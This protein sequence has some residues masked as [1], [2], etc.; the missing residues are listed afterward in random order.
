MKATRLI[1]VARLCRV[2]IAALCLSVTGVQAGIL[3]SL[4]DKVTATMSSLPRYEKLPLFDPHR[5][6]FACVY[7]DQH[8]PANDPQAEVWF[9]QALALNSPDIYYQDRD[10]PK[11]YQLYLQAAE[12]NHWKAMLNLA[13]LIVG[14][15][16]GVPEQNREIAIR[17]VEKA[18]Q[19]GVPDAYDVMGTYHQNGMIRG[20]DATSAYAFFQRAADMGSPSAMTYLGYKMAGTYDD[21]GEG[22]W[23]NLAVAVPMLECAFA[24]GYGDAGE[25]LSL[26]YARPNTPEAKLRALRVLHEG[27]KLGSAKCAS[28]IAP[29][30]RGFDLEDGSNLVGHIDKARAERYST[31]AR[32]LEFY[33]GRLKLPNLDKI[34]PLPPAPLPK[35]DGN[36]QTLIDAAK[37]VTL[38]PRARQGAMLHGREFMLE[39][40]G[41]LSLAQSP[42]AVAG[43][44]PVP[45]TGYWLALYSPSMTGAEKPA[46][47]RGQFP[48]RYQTGERFEG[49]RFE[50]LSPAEVQW[51]YLGE[52]RPLPPGRDVFLRQML[53]AGLLRQ[54]S[55]PASN[56]QCNGMQR[57]PR[58]A[59]GKAAYRQSTR[60]QH[61]TTGGNGRRLWNRASPFRTHAGTCWRSRQKAC[62]GLTSVALTPTRMHPA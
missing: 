12:R 62:N 22:F 32:A 10:Y 58:L 20:S 28:S 29:E 35:W 59:S 7:Q 41:V 18:M 26:I 3:T 43:D 31:L 1:S 23:G 2:L 30:F 54:V 39:G 50:W 45:E 55:P 16:S 47:A 53:G 40:H 46:Y 15:A 24:Q 42:Y 34:L 19:L 14:G 9:Q 61:C 49:S 38:P 17:W 5:K 33:E 60:W 13:S 44:Q 51:Q 21:P 27:V 8:V 11:I 6:S 56:L 4:T 25:K 36:K 52:A 57:C 37:A 48:E